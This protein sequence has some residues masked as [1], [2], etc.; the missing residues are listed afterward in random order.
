MKGWKGTLTLSLSLIPC[1]CMCVCEI[2]HSLSF[3]NPCHKFSELFSATLTGINFDKYEDI[4]V[5]ATGEG[6]PKN[7]G[8]FSECDFSEI[9]LNNI[10]VNLSIFSKMLINLFDSSLSITACPVCQAHSCAE[11]CHS[12]HY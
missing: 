2:K 7:V 8:S 3:L 12:H 4:P 9:I 10:A 5:E 6:C 11:V 1:L